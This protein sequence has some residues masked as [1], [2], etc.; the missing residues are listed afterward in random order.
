MAGPGSFVN[1]LRCGRIL[2]VCMLLALIPEILD[3]DM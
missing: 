1:D 2:L 3:L